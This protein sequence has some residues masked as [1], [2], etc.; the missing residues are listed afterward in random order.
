MVSRSNRN[1]SNFDELK[2]ILIKRGFEIINPGDFTVRQQAV[3]FNSA[4]HVIG[5]HG[6]GLANIFFSQASKSSLLD[7]APATLLHSHY[8]WL[9]SVCGI[10]YD[11][12]VG[13]SNPNVYGDFKV[14]LKDFENKIESFLA[15]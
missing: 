11:I 8:Y 15:S 4:S 10:K 5:I 14:E 12:L 6:A 1:I 2:P 9:A 3:I 13:G 7:I